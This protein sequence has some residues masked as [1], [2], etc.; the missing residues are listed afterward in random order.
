[1]IFT[2][3][4]QH[5]HWEGISHYLLLALIIYVIYTFFTKKNSRTISN[6]LL[7]TVVIAV[8]ILIH[9]NINIRNNK[10]TNYV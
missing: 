10:I 2:Y 7:F 1:M 5:Q 4:T 9:Q 8:D 3:D 6:I